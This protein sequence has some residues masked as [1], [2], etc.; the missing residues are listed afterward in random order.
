[1]A[2]F[3][4][5]LQNILFQIGFLTFWPNRVFE[6]FEVL[7]FPSNQMHVSVILLCRLG[8]ILCD[9]RAHLWA[10]FFPPFV[11]WEPVFPMAS[12]VC[13]LWFISVRFATGFVREGKIHE[14]V[15]ANCNYEFSFVSNSNEVLAMQLNQFNVI[16][17]TSRD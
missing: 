15:P 3:I 14:R 8:C 9:S 10:G 7:I 16:L 11:H 4:H 17:I 5:L 6:P 1:M 2:D 13:N 12:W